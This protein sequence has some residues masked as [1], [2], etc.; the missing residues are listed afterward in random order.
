MI[1]EPV[2][3]IAMTDYGVHHED[4]HDNHDNHQNCGQLSPTLVI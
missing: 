2:L 3:S 4:Y 1:F